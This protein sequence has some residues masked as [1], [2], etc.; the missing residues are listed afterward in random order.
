MILPNSRIKPHKGDDGVEPA[1]GLAG[2]GDAVGKLG[3]V[4]SNKVEGRTLRAYVG[5]RI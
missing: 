2:G 1:M 5:L 3:H 4:F